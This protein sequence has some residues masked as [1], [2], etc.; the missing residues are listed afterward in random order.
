MLEQLPEMTMG[1]IIQPDLDTLAVL[2][3]PDKRLRQ[4]AEDLGEIDGFLAEL[5]ERMETL[6]DQHAGA[7]LAATQVGWPYRFVV[8]NA[9]AQQGGVDYQAL[10]NPAIVER[11]GRMVMDEGCLSVPGIRAKVKRADYV[12]VRAQTLEGDDVLIEGEGFLAQLLQ[13]EIDHLDG[14]LFV[15]MVGPASRILIKRRLK[16]LARRDD[17][18]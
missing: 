5:A 17:G 6:S 15:D 11:D 10:I 3:Y 13:H 9:K 16:E 1:K 14:Q 8:I 18:K 4:R 7:G 2:C 12:K